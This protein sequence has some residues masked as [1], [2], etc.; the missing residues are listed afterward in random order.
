MRK[1]RWIAFLRTGLE[2]K[3]Y[4][5]SLLNEAK[6]QFYNGQY[7]LARLS[8]EDLIVQLSQSQ[9]TSPIGSTPSITPNG[10]DGN[11]Q[12]SLV[13]VVLA[14][15]MILIL[16]IFLLIRKTH[17]LQSISRVLYRRNHQVSGKIPP[18]SSGLSSPP[19]L[20]IPPVSD[21][22]SA[23][24][25]A[26]RGLSQPIGSG[27]PSLK[28]SSSPRPGQSVS[29][30]SS[31]TSLLNQ[32]IEQILSERPH[33][34]IEDEKL[35]QLLAEKQGSAFESDV[36]NK[37]LLPKT[38]VWRLVRRLERERLIYIVKVDNQNLIKLII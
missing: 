17:Y 1:A 36:R 29:L 24:S 2:N 28:S 32:A 4:F 16:G 13:T 35:L 11:Y 25:D 22:H 30:R 3:Y 38:S 9:E 18:T 31:R 20:P 8:A 10:S 21:S 12:W 6:A 5:E 27:E 15:L 37:L 33:L 14:I 26:S 23:E 7:D 19:G 34:H